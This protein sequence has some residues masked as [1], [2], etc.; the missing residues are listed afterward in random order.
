[1][2]SVISADLSYAHAIAMS[3]GKLNSPHNRHALQTNPAFS[4]PTQNAERYGLDAGRLDAVR[5]AAS[6]SSPAA[7]ALEVAARACDA[8]TAPA[9]VTQ[10]VTLVRRGEGRRTGSGPYNFACHARLRC[11]SRLACDR[12]FHYPVHV[13]DFACL[14]AC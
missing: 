6:R 11:S 5:V 14:L 3:G 2:L 7:E 12:A 4:M 13:I 1:M 9:L 8:A 10:L